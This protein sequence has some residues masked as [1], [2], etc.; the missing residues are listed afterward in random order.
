MP[1]SSDGSARIGDGARI[2]DSLGMRCLRIRQRSR[3]LKGSGP[4]VS[5]AWS[6]S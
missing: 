4:A 5:W 2:A 6:E 3:V 1:V